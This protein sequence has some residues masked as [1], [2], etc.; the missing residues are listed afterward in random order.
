MF[1]LV[2]FFFLVLVLHGVLLHVP[3][4]GPLLARL[5]F[6]GYWAVAIFV[7][8]FASRAANKLVER[9]RFRRRVRELGAVDTPR[10][11][12]KLGALQLAVGRYR[13]AEKNLQVAFDAQPE[14]LD[15]ALA[16]GRVKATLGDYQAAGSFFSRVVFDDAQFGYGEA[17]LGL[18]EAARML[19]R[20]D[21]ALRA[22]EDHDKRHG[23]NPRSA[24]ERGLCLRAL[25]RKD[26]A[27]VA[28]GE[29]LSLRSELPAFRRKGYGA[30]L[31]KAL[32]ARVS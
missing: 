10:N 16:L 17:F 6:F 8:I 25:G 27:R 20:P 28:F 5:G 3:V 15:W 26:E 1:R 9:S 13:E 7:S 2:G 24:Y 21:D 29:V 12:G 31:W 18:A 32:V 14:V 23:P 4:I 11:L 19:G 22:I 30:L